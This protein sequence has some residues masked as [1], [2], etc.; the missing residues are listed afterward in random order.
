[1]RAEELGADRIIDYR[2]QN[3]TRADA[4][5]DVV[6]DAFGK[7]GF[8][9]AA[10]VLSA[11]GYYVTTTGTPLLA[12]WAVWRK[13]AGGRHIMLGNLRDRQEDYADL[14]SLLKSGAVKPVVEKVFPFDQ[15]KE[16]FATLE[17]GGTVGKVVIRIGENDFAVP[18]GD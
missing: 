8:G 7:L 2:D 6:Y 5:Y 13:L 17:A 14:E 1:V 15:I 16:A 10:R 18:S 3:F 12:L 4:T 9:A 11:G